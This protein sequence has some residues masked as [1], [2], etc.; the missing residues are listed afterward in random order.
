[1]TQAPTI[2]ALPER[3]DADGFYAAIGG[4]AKYDVRLEID[5][6]L[7]RLAW[8]NSG[9]WGPKPKPCLVLKGGFAIRHVYR[10]TRLSA[11]A[12]VA[13]TELLGRGGGKLL[14]PSELR[15]DDVT[16]AKSQ[17][18]ERWNMTLTPVV[19]TK[20]LRVWA[21]VN[22][23]R[24]VRLLPADKK[25]FVSA[26]LPDILVWVARIDEILGEKSSG[27]ISYGYGDQDRIKDAFDL[28]FLLSNGHAAGLRRDWFV[29]VCSQQTITTAMLPC[30]TS[31]FGVHF[32]AALSGKNAARDWGRFVTSQILSGAR[33]N[34][35]TVK[36]ELPALAQKFLG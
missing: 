21:D 4:Q 16:Q 30:P 2:P 8:L 10:G 5:Y 15:L 35:Q 22:S 34:F 9:V 32:R 36:E 1:M 29:W 27:L 20:T 13:P 11:D 17:K 7:C 19:G 14:L 25:T 18:L 24:P 26:F 6:A 33:P 28:W 12:D 23:Q 3:L 31:G